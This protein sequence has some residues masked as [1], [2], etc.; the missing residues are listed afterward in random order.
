MI[1]CL[2]AFCDQNIPGI[3]SSAMGMCFMLCT[4]FFHLAS[5]PASLDSGRTSTSNSNNNASLH[6]VKGMLLGKLT[7]VLHL[8][9]GVYGGSWLFSFDHLFTAFFLN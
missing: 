3:V 4:D 8:M 6:E 7:H 2:G 5:R 9:W 1:S